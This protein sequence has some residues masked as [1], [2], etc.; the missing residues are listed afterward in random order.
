M[1]PWQQQGWDYNSA[2]WDAQI[3]PMMY[4]LYMKNFAIHTNPQVNCKL[5]VAYS[6][7]GIRRSRYG[8]WG[9]LESLEQVGAKDM[10]KNA[11]KYQSLVDANSAKAREL[12][13]VLVG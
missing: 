5:F 11:P 1:Q 3:H 8:S 12:N 10:I 13:L 2:V 7:I 6:Y 9:H 4:D